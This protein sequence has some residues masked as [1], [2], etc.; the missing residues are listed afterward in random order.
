MKETNKYLI[1]NL[2]P[3]YTPFLLPD[4]KKILLQQDVLIT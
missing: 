3:Y 2:N 1:Q 4:N